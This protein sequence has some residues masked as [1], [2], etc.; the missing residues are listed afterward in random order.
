[1]I[2]RGE[3]DEPDDEDERLSNML[4]KIALYPVASVPIARDVV[5]GLGTDFGYNSS[6]VASLL[7]RGILGSKQATESSF[8]DSEVTRTSIKNA[9]KLIGAGVGLPGIG[10]GWKSADHI[11]ETIE[12]G[13]DFSVRQLLLGPDRK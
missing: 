13:E 8:T 12:E 1:M 10:Q 11:F 3:L 2:L 9:S 4:T 7:E 6:P 5:S